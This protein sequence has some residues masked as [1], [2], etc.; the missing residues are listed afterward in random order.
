MS[1]E[2]QA[3][4]VSAR[5]R[6]LRAATGDGIAMS[7]APLTHRSMV[8]VELATADGRVGFGESWTNYPAWATTERVATLREGVLPLVLG[9][10]SRRITELQRRLVAA[11]E[12][13][14]RQ[15]GAP[16]P[17]MQAISAVDIALW[18]LH[19]RTAGQAIS[20]LVGGRVRD[21]SPV[22]ASSLGP[23]GVAQQGK[24]CVNDGHTAVKVKLGFDRERDERILAEAREAIGPDI[25]LYADANQAWS[26]DEAARMAPVLAAFDVA[27]LEEPVRGNRLD[28]LEELH[29]RTG[30]MIATGE[31][32]YGR[33]EFRRYAASPAIAILQPDIAKTGGFTEALAICQLADAYRKPVLPHLYGGAVAF[34]ATLQLAACAPA[35]QGVEYDIRDNPLRDPLLIDAPRPRR[36]RIPLPTGSG[37]G[38]DLDP[39][40]VLKRTEPED[41]SEEELSA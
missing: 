29:R 35:V 27:W 36:G 6:V 20:S 21:E 14:G 5:L 23:K 1:A 2:T 10:D 28:E 8:L 32:V 3:S 11:L 26:V 24:R 33:E 40:A 37:L 34:A 30:M 41:P 31:N 4:I 19:G 17:I 15:W 7:F 12:P 18:D 38:I 39:S 25:E 22:Y 9:Q 16:G 13:V